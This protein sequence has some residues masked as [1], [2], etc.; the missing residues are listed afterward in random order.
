LRE[1]PFIDITKIPQNNHFLKTLEKRSVEK[2]KI[3]KEQVEKWFIPG[4]ERAVTN[5][6]CGEHGLQ[7]SR[8][9]GVTVTKNKG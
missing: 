7:N 6:N 4:C 9:Q 2:L 1:I 5:R 3:E 8:E